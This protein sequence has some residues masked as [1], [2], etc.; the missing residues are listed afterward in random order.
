MSIIVT[1]EVE[2]KGE[3]RKNTWHTKK[4]SEN[5]PS[6]KQWTKPNAKSTLVQELFKMFLY[7][8]SVTVGLSQSQLPADRT[9]PDLFSLHPYAKT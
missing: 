2:I 5:N 3:Q 9:T 1:N 8:N 7:Q 6:Q 4:N